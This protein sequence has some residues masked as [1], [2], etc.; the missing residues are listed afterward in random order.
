MRASSLH[1]WQKNLEQLLLSERIIALNLWELDFVNRIRKHFKNLK[2]RRTTKILPGTLKALFLGHLTTR[3][4]SEKGHL[5][6]RIGC[7]RP[8]S[9]EYKC[10]MVEV[11]NCLANINLRITYHSLNVTKRFINCIILSAL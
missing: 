2:Y 7:F 9:N 3:L 5:S 10:P 6:L 1:I 4:I 8:F 11:F